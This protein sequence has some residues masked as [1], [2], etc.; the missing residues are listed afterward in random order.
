MIDQ[1]MNG[2]HKS[3]TEN[4]LYLDAEL[5]LTKL[6]K[7]VGMH[8][9]ILSAV[10]NQKLGKSFNEYINQFR[11]EEVKDRLVKAENKKYTIAS[12]AYECGFNSQ[13]TFQR[14][15]KSVVGLTPR[16]FLQQNGDAA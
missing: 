13:P 11:V 8:P 14:A 16:E 3:M 1:T 6:S 12:V 2:L 15:F 5:N 9:K 4:K 10:L 7:H